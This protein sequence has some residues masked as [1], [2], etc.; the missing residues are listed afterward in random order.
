MKF[1]ENRLLLC[2]LDLKD[3]YKNVKKLIEHKRLMRNGSK[4]LKRKE[5]VYS[6]SVFLY[7][8]QIKTCISQ[9]MEIGIVKRGLIYN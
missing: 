4:L 7:I 9:M 6:R 2:D 8:F 3:A 5:L 1:L